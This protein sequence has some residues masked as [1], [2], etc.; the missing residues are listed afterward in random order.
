MKNFIK[1]MKALSD[2]NRVKIIK[3]LE[4]KLMCVCELQEVQ[5]DVCMRASGGDSG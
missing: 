4:Y 2:P 5:I 3:M 1:I